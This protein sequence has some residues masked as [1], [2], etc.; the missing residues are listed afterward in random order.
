MA[1]GVFTNIDELQREVE[2]HFKSMMK[3]KEMAQAGKRASEAMGRYVMDQ[4]SDGGDSGYDFEQSGDFHSLL[5]SEAKHGSVNQSQNSLSMGFGYIPEMNEGVEARRNFQTQVHWVG[6][7]KKGRYVTIN[8][9]QEKEMPKWI[10]AEFGS[11]RRADRANM[12][13][14]LKVRYTPRSGKE[15]MYGPSSEKVGGEGGGEKRGYFMVSRDGF[16]NLRGDKRYKPKT[17]PGVKAGRIFRK[18]LE[19]SKEE[20]RE[21]LA[22][23]I[24]DFLNN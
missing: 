20:V 16:N 9:K 17:H 5:A 4:V 7:K 14:E 12:P 23:G 21:I 1:K 24:R 15:Y 19:K 8:L 2:A 10:I 18:G 6:S 11:G 13:K 22:D 3:S